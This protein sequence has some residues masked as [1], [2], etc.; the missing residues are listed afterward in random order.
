MVTSGGN[1]PLF[2]PLL[3]DANLTET[4]LIDSIQYHRMQTYP[5]RQKISPRL[6]RGVFAAK[7]HGRL[8]RSTKGQNTSTHNDVI[9]INPPCP[10][11]ST[12]NVTGTAP[13]RAG[14]KAKRDPV[15]EESAGLGLQPQWTIRRRML[16]AAN[17]CDAIVR[18][19]CMWAR[20]PGPL[21]PRFL[22][23]H[24]L[25][26]CNV[27]TMRIKIRRLRHEVIGKC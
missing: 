13:D 4:C 22:G 26:L 17:R 10:T 20:P 27:R 2:E 12:R 11:S 6:K 24:S 19:Q 8:K 23:I 1:N 21:I 18:L 16:G 25:Q 5:E 3:A 9:V 14:K 15:A 7:S